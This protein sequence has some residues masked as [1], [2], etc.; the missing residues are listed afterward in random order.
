MHQSPNKACISML[1]NQNILSNSPRHQLIQMQPTN[2]N[3]ETNINKLHCPNIN[4]VQYSLPSTIP[5]AHAIYVQKEINGDF[6][7]LPTTTTTI[8]PQQSSIFVPQTNSFRDS[9]SQSLQYI[10]MPNNQNF[11]MDKSQRN[12]HP[13]MNVKQMHTATVHGEQTIIFI[14][15]ISI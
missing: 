13:A 14:R 9:A 15:Q 10:Q 1:P 6:Y 4:S 12:S 5:T 2:M 7:L 8:T 3:L 11:S